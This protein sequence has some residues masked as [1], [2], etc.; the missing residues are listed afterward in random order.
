M[1]YTNINNLEEIIKTLRGVKLEEEYSDYKD[2][3]K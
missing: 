1:S 3:K 2:L